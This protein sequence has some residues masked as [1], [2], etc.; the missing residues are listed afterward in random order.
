SV[1][2]IVSSSRVEHRSESEQSPSLKFLT[3]CE[4]RLFQRPDEAIHRGFDKQA[5][6][7]LSGSRN[8]ISNFEP[9]NHADIQHMAERIVD[10]DAF[11]K[12]MQDLLRS[13]LQDKDAEFVVCSATPRKIGN[14]STKNPRYLQSRPDMTNPFPRYVAERGLRLHRTIPMSKPAP[15]PV[16]S[17]LMGRRNNPPDK[18]A[19]IRS[20]AVYNPIHYQEL[21]ELFM[22]LI[23]SL[24]GKS[25]STTGFGSEGALTKG[26]FNM[27]RYAADLNATLVSYLL[28]DLKGFSTAAGHIGP[29]VQVDHDISLLIP[30]VWCRLE[31]HEREPAHLIAEGSLEK[32]N[33][34]EYKG[35]MIPVSRLGYRITRRF[36]RNYFGRI[37]D[38]PLSVFDENILKPEVQDADSFYDGVKYICDAH[39]QVAEQYLEDGTAEQLCPP[40]RALID[41]MASGSYQG[42]TVDSPELRNMFT[43]ES[44]LQSEWYRDRLR[45]KQAS[46]LRL[47]TR[48][49][50]YLQKRSAEFTGKDQIRMLR[51]E[52]RQAWLKAR[53]KEIQSDSYLKSLQGTLGLDPCMT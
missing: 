39:R 34:V 6:A 12:P 30:E 27:L 32:L 53:L 5:E 44:L 26:P 33:D 9:L 2:T 7:D 49:L 51:L 35:E 23:C 18:A 25:P 41:I 31:P 15:F 4:Y 50:E 28:T 29:N 46:D 8:F 1:S 42:M 14:V 11:S 45:N 19:G 40:L 20:L 47:M 37:F 21:P 38:H 43:R 10:F 16:H 52:D 13:M 24:T 17:V 36:V 48:H 3:N 22:D